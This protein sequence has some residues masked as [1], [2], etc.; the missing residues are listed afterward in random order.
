MH[1]KIMYIFV[2]HNLY[3]YKAKLFQNE[4]KCII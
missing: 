1:K 3:R 4:K 2:M